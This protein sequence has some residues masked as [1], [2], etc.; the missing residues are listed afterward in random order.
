[1]SEQ[2][3]R[4][5]GVDTRHEKGCVRRY[6]ATETG[7]PDTDEEAARCACHKMW[8]EYLASAPSPTK[9]I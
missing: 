7:E 1:M 2:D 3:I 6:G 8:A 9:R 4:E 5:L